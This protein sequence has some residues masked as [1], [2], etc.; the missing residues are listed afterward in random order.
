MLNKIPTWLTVILILIF[1][2]GLF[3]TT[4]YLL[5]GISKIPIVRTVLPPRE[6]FTTGV[7]KFGSQF[8]PKRDYCTGASYLDSFDGSALIEKDTSVL[9]RVDKNSG[10]SDADLFAKTGSAVGVK[11]VFSKGKSCGV[12]KSCDC[13]DS[14]TVES[15]ALNK[16]KTE[17]YAKSL[18]TFEGTT[19]CFHAHAVKDEEADT[20]VCVPVL[21]TSNGFYELVDLRDAFHLDTQGQ[22]L[23]VYGILDPDIS[24]A[25]VAGISGYI[26][27]DFVENIR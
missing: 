21:S 14:L 10:I 8:S 12:K 4:V 25:N 22:H 23:R 6:V 16:V 17:Q 19:A 13:D 26:Y 15:L 24:T 5:G 11:G 7:V 18:P 1:A 2:A 3:L 20:S 9:L 27:A